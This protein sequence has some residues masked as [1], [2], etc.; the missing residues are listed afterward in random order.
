MGG[1]T[2]RVAVAFGND[3][4]AGGTL[5]SLLVYEETPVRPAPL[6]TPPPCDD[7][8]PGVGEA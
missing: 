8:G 6:L 3:N 1:A 4:P 2:D 5:I 7:G